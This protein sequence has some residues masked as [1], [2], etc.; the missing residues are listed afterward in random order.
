MLF[1]IGAGLLVAGVSQFFGYALEFALKRGN[2]DSLAL[3]AML[4]GVWL[5]ARFP[6]TMWLQ[7]LCLSF[8]AHLKVYPALL[9]FLPFWR[10]GWRALPPVVAINTVMLFYFGL[11]RGREFLIGLYQYASHPY[12]W[13]GNHSP[14]SRTSCS[15]RGWPGHCPASWFTA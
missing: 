15:S 11:D 14:P 3:A 7:V 1:A 9:L 12:I 2:Y 5:G 13:I 6:R 8:A 10:H 4:T